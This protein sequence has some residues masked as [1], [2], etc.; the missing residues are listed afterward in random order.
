M[1]SYTYSSAFFSNISEIYYYAGTS[2][3]YYGTTFNFGSAIRN[4]V[5]ATYCSTPYFLAILM[6][7]LCINI[8][9]K[10]QLPSN[11]SYLFISS[12]TC[13]NLAVR[14]VLF[15]YDYN[16]ASSKIAQRVKPTLASFQALGTANTNLMSER[17]QSISIASL[18]IDKDR[19]NS[20]IIV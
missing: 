3:S 20:L 14:V 13:L 18:I 19:S 17:M 9:S 10:S 15:L 12:N 5:D 2:I 11:R 16:S 4:K 8:P 1:I 7:T 6:N